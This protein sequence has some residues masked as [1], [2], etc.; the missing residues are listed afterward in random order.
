[1]KSI[2]DVYTCGVDALRINV[3]RRIYRYPVTSWLACLHRSRERHWTESMRTG[4]QCKI[5][6]P[7]TLILKAPTEY[8]FSLTHTY[9]H[10][11]VHR[12]RERE[13]QREFTVGNQSSRAKTWLN[14][15]SQVRTGQWN[16]ILQQTQSNFPKWRGNINEIARYVQ[17]SPQTTVL[18]AVNNKPHSLTIGCSNDRLKTRLFCTRCSWPWNQRL[19]WLSQPELAYYVQ[20]LYSRS[21]LSTSI[22]FHFVGYL[23]FVAFAIDVRNEQRSDVVY[24][25]TL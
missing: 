20:C 5:A 11:D 1:M 25:S 3:K 2:L 19:Y 17:F 6:S 14:Q 10:K 16:S 4:S 24:A 13:E 18:K 15:A 12:E 22:M 7:F 21:L 8:A 23:V 9:T